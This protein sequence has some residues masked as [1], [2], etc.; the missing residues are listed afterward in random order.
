MW[1][2]AQKKKVEI[3]K[4]KGISKEYVEFLLQEQR[5]REPKSWYEKLCKFS[6]VLRIKPP[7]SMEEKLKLDIAFSSLNVS[8]TGVISAS[9]LAFLLAFVAIIPSIFLTKDVSTAIFFFLIPVALF[10]YLYT[11]PSFQA[12]V[13]R[14]QAGEEAIKIILYMSIYLKL[15]PSLEGA[16]NFA[17]EHSKGPITEDIKKAMWDLHTGKYKTVEEALG[18][19]TQKWVWWNEDFV[20]ALSLIYGVLIEPTERGREEILRKA[21]SFILDS[22][23]N[24][25][26]SYVEEV[27]SPIM[28][29]H[30]MG[31]LLPAMGLLMFPMV[32]IFLHQQISTPQLILGYV[33]LLPLA[34]YFFIK[35]ILQKRPGA[36]MVP[37]ISKHPEL[38][39]EDYFEIK[40]GNNRFWV[41]IFILSLLLGF[42]VMSYGILHFIDLSFN[43]AS[44]PPDIHS[45]LGCDRSITP[46]KC[47]LMNE[48]KMTPTNLLATFSIT[49]GFGVMFISY[50]YL[51]SFQRIRIRNEVKNIE[52]EFRLGLFSLGNYLSEGYPIEVGMQ[53]TLEE[54]EKLGMQKRPSYSFFKRLYQN[55]KNFGMTFKRALFDQKEGI[56]KFYPSV[57]IEDVMKILADASEKSA[58]LLGMIAKTIATYLE[59]IYA[60][61]ARI[62]ELLAETRSALRLQASFI[63]PMVTGIISSLAI[64]ILEMLRILAEKL[65]QI[66]KML[67]TSLIQGAGQGAKSFLDILVG[68]FENIMP[69][70]VLQASIGIYT[71]EAVALFTLLLSGIENGFDK[72][73]R[74]WEIS[75][76]LIKA[77]L[78]YGVVSIMSL[79]A[80]WGIRGVVEAA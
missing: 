29:L 72:T 35:R 26:K 50:F 79:L 25:M 63:I 41:P 55:M 13:T 54:Y 68:G 18:K 36:F 31:L 39:P 69:M 71:V 14:I 51:R 48:A 4:R 42:I 77:I 27:S 30:V 28:L 33:F 1:P 47:I 16:I 2:F 44:P 34:N 37:D 62:K 40:F 80:F 15:N 8:P 64:F 73:A 67:G 6:E 3:D 70:T 21:L 57:L 60:I 45:R 38:P 10:W 32:S 59:N 66:E 12:N 20:R 17:I 23:H 19:Y 65:S 43:L 22:T 74:D 7:K 49:A 9:I 5:L 56:L 61:E 52:E 76:N 75:Q 24:K 53:K 78:V 46:V 58:V 11:Y